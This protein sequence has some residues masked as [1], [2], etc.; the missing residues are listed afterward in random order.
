MQLQTD[1][2][3]QEANNNDCPTSTNNGIQ[4]SLAKHMH[5]VSPVPKLSLIQHRETVCA[6]TNNCE[7]LGKIAMSKT[8]TLPG[9]GTPET[10]IQIRR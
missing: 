7:E 6:D 10:K 8:I 9:S 5:Q 2:G 3:R 4:A 1:A